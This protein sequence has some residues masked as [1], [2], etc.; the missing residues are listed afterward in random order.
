MVNI[1]KNVQLVELRIEKEKYVFRI[2]LDRDF[3]ANV[4][5]L[6]QVQAKNSEVAVVGLEIEPLCVWDGDEV[7]ATGEISTLYLDFRGCF[8]LEVQ[9][10]GVYVSEWYELP[11]EKKLQKAIAFSGKDE[12]KCRERSKG[13]TVLRR[14]K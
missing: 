11:P 14:I 13:A 2:F 5:K 3:W 7:I 9:A 12:Y 8:R 4:A 10:N 1:L 6:R